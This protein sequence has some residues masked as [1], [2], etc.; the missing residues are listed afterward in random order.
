[1]NH[2]V[3]SDD[4]EGAFADLSPAT[5]G[6]DMDSQTTFDHRDHGL[7]LDSFSIG[8]KVKTDLH[9]PSVLAGYWFVGGGGLEHQAGKQL[10]LSELSR[11]ISIEINPRVSPGPR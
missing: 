10:R 9:Q 7:H 8:L 4:D 3:V 6:P 11:A 5:S 1:M 2:E